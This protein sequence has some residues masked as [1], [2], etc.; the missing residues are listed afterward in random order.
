MA[1]GLQREGDVL[2]KPF[3]PPFYKDMEEA[4]LAFVAYKFAPGMGTF[5][6]GGVAT[7]SKRRRGG[8]GGYPELP[9]PDDRRDHHL[10]PL[11]PPVLR[12]LPGQ[13]RFVLH[14]AGN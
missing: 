12:T 11:R 8:A 1:I 10:L 13:H 3:R 4:V 14:R 7:S 5:R 9:R 6:D 2:L